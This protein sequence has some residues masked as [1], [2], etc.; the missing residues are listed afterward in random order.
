MRFLKVF[1]FLG[2]SLATL[3]ALAAGPVNATEIDFDHNGKGGTLTPYVKVDFRCDLNGA[4]Y[5]GKP[6]EISSGGAMG[7]IER[8]SS[9]ISSTRLSS[10]AMTASAR[11]TI[12]SGPMPANPEDQMVV[13][14]GWASVKAGEF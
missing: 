14:L 1:S 9:H 6:V 13:I 10:F 5:C 12:G 8:M 11:A 3:L 7:G 2:V 4:L